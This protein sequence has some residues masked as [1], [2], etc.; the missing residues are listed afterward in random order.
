[1]EINE[2]DI[3]KKVETGNVRVFEKTVYWDLRVSDVRA[4]ALQSDYNPE[5][6]NV[7]VDGRC[8]KRKIL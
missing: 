3:L 6:V 2:L 8:W 5:Y 4:G 1:M 7:G